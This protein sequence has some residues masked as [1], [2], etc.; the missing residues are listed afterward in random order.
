RR[1]EVAGE[2]LP[3]ELQVAAAV[4]G[5][6]D[7]VGEAG[8]AFADHVP[9]HA[10]VVHAGL[11]GGEA[12]LVVDVVE[13]DVPHAAELEALVGRD[14]PVGGRRGDH[15]DLVVVQVVVPD[16]RELR[17]QPARRGTR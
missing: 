8:I 10:V 14:V 13:R 4:T 11:V 3:A 16:G 7:P 17:G 15:H 5:P 12:G 2:A 9:D 1:G 6:L